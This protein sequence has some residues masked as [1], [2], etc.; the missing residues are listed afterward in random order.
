MRKTNV[1]TRVTS[2]D[3]VLAKMVSPKVYAAENSVS[4]MTVYR[5]LKAGQIPGAT[6]F[7]SQWRIPRDATFMA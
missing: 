6:K 3:P 5:A 7:R 4:T 1:R 2:P